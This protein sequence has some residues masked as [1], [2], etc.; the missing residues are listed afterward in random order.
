[1]THEFETWWN[2][3]T[4]E[5]RVS[6]DGMIHLLELHGPA[7]GP[8]YSGEVSG[9]R[10]SQ[11]LRQLLVPHQDG[12]ICI[13]YFSDGVAARLVLLTGTTKGTGD[14]ICPPADVERADAVYGDYL[15][16]RG[17]H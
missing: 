17:S 10:Y 5:E 8:P 7:L 1:M 2:A 4:E 13:L 3:L 14:E 15:A 12:Q 6:I 11:Q 9:S 16:G